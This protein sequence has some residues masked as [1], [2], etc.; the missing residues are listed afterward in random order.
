MG[1]LNFIMDTRKGCLPCPCGGLHPPR[2]NRMGDSVDVT[3]PV[4]PEIYESY[5]LA[6]YDAAAREAQ[7]DYQAEPQAPR[8]RTRHAAIGGIRESNREDLLTTVYGFLSRRHHV[9]LVVDSKSKKSNDAPSK[10]CDTL[11][12][13]TQ[14][15]SRLSR[16]IND[17]LAAS[18]K[19][20]IDY[21]R[22]QRLIKDLKDRELKNTKYW[23]VEPPPAP[24]TKEER[25]LLFEFNTCTNREAIDAEVRRWKDESGERAI[26]QEED[27]QLGLKPGYHAPAFNGKK[28]LGCQKPR[29]SEPAA[30]I[31]GHPI[32]YDEPDGDYGS[33]M[34][35]SFY[36]RTDP[37]EN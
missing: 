33:R 15:L 21:Q 10:H 5:T 12:K 1:G 23:K 20:A 27:K 2:V 22:I 30:D 19:T 34:A 11:I 25:D 14:M 35:D 24:F 3:C 28:K 16:D 8:R 31:T 6:E 37:N 32:G 17:D 18:G 4:D 36:E 9:I 26:Q 7:A 29:Y 13:R